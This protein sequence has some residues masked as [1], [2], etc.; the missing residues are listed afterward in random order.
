[1]LPYFPEIQWRNVKTELAKNRANFSAKNVAQLIE[2]TLIKKKVKEKD[3]QRRLSIL[4]VIDISRHSKR[5]FWYG[6]IVTGTGTLNGYRTSTQLEEIIKEQIKTFNMNV[7]V[8]VEFHDHVIYVSMKETKKKKSKVQYPVPIF[9]ALFIN[10]KH[11]FCSK[12]TVA[13]GFIDIITMSLGF[14]HSKRLKLMGKDVKSLDQLCKAKEQ[15]AIGINDIEDIPVYKTALPEKKRTGIDF[16]QATQRKAHAEQCFDVNPPQLELV[17]TRIKNQPWIDEEL[18]SKLKDE[19]INVTWEF[20]SSSI[21]SYLTKLIER[22]I[23]VT[24]PPIYISNLM[25]LGK[26][27]FSIVRNR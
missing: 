13:Q 10:E 6:H 23:I 4:E 7:H 20:R 15:R 5:K 12:K 9:F 27:E 19:K 3:L 2:K 17:V 22:Q 16:T 11:F 24:P 21:S 26:N 18:H 14:S 25:K 1:M 8:S